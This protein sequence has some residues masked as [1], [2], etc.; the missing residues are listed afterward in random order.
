MAGWQAVGLGQARQ[1]AQLMQT[2]EDTWPPATLDVGAGYRALRERDDLPGAIDY[3]AHALS[4]AD[5]VAWAAHLLDAEARAHPLAFRDRLAL[6][7][8]LRW[9]GEPTDAHRRAA[10][11]AAQAAGA[12]SP[13]RCLGLAVFATGGSI[14]AP[15]LPPVQPP[16]TATPRYVA[17]AIKQ[18][19]HRGGAPETF[20]A[21]ALRLGEAVAERGAAALAKAVA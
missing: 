17:G 15:G 6:D 21:R 8:A 19:G 13:E 12:R 3:L 9:A 7:T 1:V 14:A 18:A 4:R 10:H 11:D 2:D 16:P 5:A 20:F